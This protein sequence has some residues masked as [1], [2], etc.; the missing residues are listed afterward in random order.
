M[1]WFYVENDAQAG[2]VT[3]AEFAQLQAQGLIQERTLVYCQGMA[4]WMPLADARSQGF[5]TPPETVAAPAPDAAP[6]STN[7]LAGAGLKPKLANSEG[8]IACPSCGARVWDN[9][10]IPMGDRFVCVNCRDV[11]LQKIREGVNPLGSNLR[12]AGFGIRWLGLFIDGII[13]QIYSAILSVFFGLSIV[14]PVLDSMETPLL[15]VYMVLSIG[16]PLLYPVF[17]I[18]HSRFQATPGM[19]AVKIKAVRP[20]GSRITYLRSLGREL[21]SYIS[22]AL[23]GI[24]FFMMLWDPENRTLHDRMA[25]TRVIYR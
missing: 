8:M 18:G 21:A 16:V 12:Y 9:E 2:P 10:L 15:V 13:A 7:P 6:A 23:M 20:D 17:F 5:W 24:G 1:Q 4:D 25:D 3:D 19:M 22:L 14:N 11:T